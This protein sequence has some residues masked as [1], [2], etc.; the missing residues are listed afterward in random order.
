[1]IGD[2]SRWDSCPG[3]G[4]FSFQGIFAFPSDFTIQ[5]V[6]YDPG[7]G[8]IFKTNGLTIRFEQ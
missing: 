6:G 8:Q 5:G 2:E 4:F 1:M 7:S 3:P